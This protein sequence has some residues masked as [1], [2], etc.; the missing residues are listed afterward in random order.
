MNTP[1][2]SKVEFLCYFLIGVII[3]ILESIVKVTMSSSCNCKNPCGKFLQHKFLYVYELDCC[4]TNVRKN[5]V[6]VSLANWGQ[7]SDFAK[8]CGSYICFKL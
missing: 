5:K 6:V 7:N 2:P 8:Y 4:C 1:M 3:A